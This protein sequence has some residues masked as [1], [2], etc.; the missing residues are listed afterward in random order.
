M[1]DKPKPIFIDRYALRK[2]SSINEENYTG[3][4]SEGSSPLLDEEIAKRRRKLSKTLPA[5]ANIIITEESPMAIQGLSE[6]EEDEQN[7]D[8]QSV[9]SIMSIDNYDNE[10]FITDA[11]D[12]DGYDYIEYF[13]DNLDIEMGEIRSP[14]RKKTR[15][16]TV[17]VQMEGK[18]IEEEK[19]TYWIEYSL[20]AALTASAALILFIFNK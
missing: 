12:L 1:L 9:G 6:L 19:K 7:Y 8:N 2:L 4:Q 11:A 14:V 18:L 15:S 3:S 10:S 16:R 20:G 17:K 13:Q 5:E